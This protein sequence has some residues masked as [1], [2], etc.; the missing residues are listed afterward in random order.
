M[1]LSKLWNVASS[2]SGGNPVKLEP[3]AV[4]SDGDWYQSD[5]K[6]LEVSQVEPSAPS[7]AS[8]GSDQ[9]SESMMIDLQPRASE[10]MFDMQVSPISE[11]DGNPAG[12]DRETPYVASAHVWLMLLMLPEFSA[13]C[14]L[15]D[16]VRLAGTSRM[17]LE[18]S[19]AH[20]LALIQHLVAEHTVWHEDW[21]ADRSAELDLIEFNAVWFPNRMCQT[22]RLR[23][24]AEWL[25]HDECYDCYSEH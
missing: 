11:V 5:G 3:V 18:L 14:Y 19:V 15:D 25:G 20:H 24:G 13:S 22:C 4:D 16:V 1:A 12:S 17:A 9:G 7:E 2:S 6:R 10:A 21:C 23:P 8:T